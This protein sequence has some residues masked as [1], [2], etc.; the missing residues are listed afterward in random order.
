[1][2]D[3]NL[4]KSGIYGVLKVNWTLRCETPL[5]VRNGKSIQ[6]KTRDEKR[7]KS[8][9]KGVSFEWQQ[10]NS[11][12]DAEHTVAALHF[13]YRVEDGQ[14]KA[15]HFIPP[16]SL[17]GSLRS[18][19]IN[20][21]VQPN[22]RRKMSPPKKEDEA[23]TQEYL[24][25][26]QDALNKSSSGYPWIA[27]MFGLA[28]ET[29]VGEEGIANAGRLSMETKPFE[30]AHPQPIAINGEP[31]QTLAGPNNA[32]RHMVVRNPLDRMTHASKEK[33]LHQ[34]LE[35]SRGESFEVQMT[36]RNP[37]NSDLGLLSLWRREL[38][39]GLLRLGALS[40]IGRG[41]VYITGEEYQLWL[42]PDAPE[43]VDPKELSS[44]EKPGDALA[45]LWNGYE[46][47]PEKLN[48]FVSALELT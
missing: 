21:I 34:F 48:Q 29:R 8:R 27:S 11:S 10:P 25:N 46:I 5:A 23:K 20:H 22:F 13:G 12:S 15:I 36:I 45:T 47:P 17:R 14:L 38:N 2:Y 41:R 19:T 24:D 4:Y 31:E 1:M 6:Y 7:T 44:I 26:L 30:N 3:P 40:S 16:S 37:I 9:G 42:G 33:G 32:Q 18:W 35:F 28:L 39:D 43:I